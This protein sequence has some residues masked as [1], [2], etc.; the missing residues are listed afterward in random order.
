MASD[1]QHRSMTT[2]QFISGADPWPHRDWWSNLSAEGSTWPTGEEGPDDV[3]VGT[4]HDDQLLGT[5]GD[6]SIDGRKGADTMVGGAGNDVYFVDNAGDEVHELLGEGTDTINT[7]I[8]F[9]LAA[10][11]ENLILAGTSGIDG[12]GN[13]LAN[14]I[15]GNRAAN[16]IDGGQ[17]NDTLLGKGGMDTL[18]GGSGKDVLNGGDDADSLDGGRGADK[19]VGGLGDDTFRVDS[20]G[21]QTIEEVDGG[22]DT[23]YSSLS[24][25]LAAHVDNLTLTGSADLQGTGNELDNRLEGNQGANVLFGGNGYDSIVGH[26]GDDTLLGADG[27]DS[28][29]GSEGNDSLDGGRGGDMMIGGLGDDTFVVDDITDSTFELSVGG[30]DTVYSSITLQLAPEVENLFLT[31]TFT[32]INGYGNDSD[33]LLRDNSGENIL[34]GGAGNDTILGGQHVSVFSG[35]TLLGGLGDDSIQGGGSNAQDVLYGGAGND[36]LRAAGNGGL[37][38]EEGNDWLVGGMGGGPKPRANYLW[39]GTGD[40]TLEAGGA[41]D[42]GDG[43]DLIRGESSAFSVSGG[44]GDDTFTGSGGDPSLYRADLGA[45]DDFM[46]VS[47]WSPAKVI[48]GDGADRVAVSSTGGL[49]VDGGNGNDWLDLGTGSGGK[50]AVSG[51]EGD[52]H[53]NA[54]GYG[55]VVSGDA[56]ND[57]INARCPVATDLSVSGG[58]GMDTISATGIGYRHFSGGADDDRFV[59]LS[60]EVLGQEMLWVDDF[61]SGEDTIALSQST[62]PVG[63]GDLTVEGGII[64]A[65]PGGFDSSAELVLVAADVVGNLTLDACAAA[66]GSAN[67][68]YG[69]GQTAVF[70][71]G[72]ADET[73]TL[74]F[75]SSGAD[76]TVSGSELSIVVRLSGGPSPQIGDVVWTG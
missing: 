1:L 68:A 23:V 54:S 27:F 16:R 57:V 9:T 10:N 65:S 21:D 44:L 46:D 58:D 28:L 76:A 4:K 72:N 14:R 25:S 63:D 51:G 19:M 64:I 49:T 2:W 52:D 29:D 74:Y 59:M 18:I 7:R 11:V 67:Q 53:I 34:D 37:Y 48:A 33:N 45:G 8:G 43:N 12:V 71:V 30:L 22:K 35:D 38:G 75:E 36:T 39:G 24:W 69:Q 62:L 31:G 13:E 5:G 26:A 20:L 56:G 15:D 40:D 17:G 60:T 55:G 61:A 3:I 50:L 42:G 70:V 6:D 73:W 47:I 41:M 32:D 66:I